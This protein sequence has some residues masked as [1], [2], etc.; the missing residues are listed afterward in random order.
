MVYETKPN[1]AKV[2]VENGIFNK[3]GVENLQAQRKPIIKV[4]AN[5]DGKDVEIALYFKM[6]YDEVAER[7]TDQYFVTTN[8]NKMLKGKVEDPYVANTNDSQQEE[9][10]D[11]VPF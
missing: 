4:K 2:F 5:V 11:E 1:T 6:V 7:Y 3:T 8:G 9:F 10:E